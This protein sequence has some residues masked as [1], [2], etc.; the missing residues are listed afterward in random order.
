M[1][2]RHFF[3]VILLIL[4]C[5]SSEVFLRSDI[6]YSKYRR[7]AVFP[8][9]DYPGRPGSGVQISD[10]LSMQLINSYYDI[11]DRS[12]TQKILQEQSLGISGIIDESTA[13]SIGKILGVQAI[14]TG[15][16]NEYQCTWTNIQIV[17]G[18]SPAYMAFSKTGLALKLIDCE[19]AQIIW[20]GSAIGT[21]IGQNSEMRAATK[22]IKNI[23]KKFKALSIAQSR[24]TKS[25][26]LT[27]TLLP[28]FRH[29]FP[30]YDSYSDEKIVKAFR[31]A[32]PQFNDKSDI[33]IIK[34]LEAK[35]VNK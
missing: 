21:E 13:P 18:G 20:A 24:R 15:S 30:K 17:Q 7:I 6:S 23:L 34:Y 5:S 12:Q 33:W 35:Y 27:T 32:Y 3:P 9:A 8:L 25:A 28:N 29:V 31:E 26:T 2:L 4:S 19:T 11:I 10:L 1:K 14:L 16:I 22:A